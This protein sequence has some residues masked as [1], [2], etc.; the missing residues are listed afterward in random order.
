MWVKKIGAVTDII[1]AWIYYR[2]WMAT[3]TFGVDTDTG[4]MVIDLS[5]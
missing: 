1:S 3:T 2:M 5:V 4:C